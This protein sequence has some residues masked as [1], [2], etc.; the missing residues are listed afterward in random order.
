VRLVAQQS[1]DPLT[2]NV[3]CPLRPKQ[4]RDGELQQQIAQRWGYSTLASSN[5]V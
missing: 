1:L 4:I 3:G 2:V 5:A